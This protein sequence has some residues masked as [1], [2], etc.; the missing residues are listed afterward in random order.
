MQVF[1]AQVQCLS[2]FSFFIRIFFGGVLKCYAGFA[3]LHILFI[4]HL[5]YFR[6]SQIIIVLYKVERIFLLYFC[7]NQKLN[8]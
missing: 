4:R 2:C 3:E 1:R 5:D 8:C 6:S 7:T